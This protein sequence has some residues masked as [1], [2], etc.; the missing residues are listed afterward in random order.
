MNRIQKHWEKAHTQAIQK[1]KHASTKIAII[2]FAFDSS[3]FVIKFMPLFPYGRI[4]LFWLSWSA[5]SFHMFAR[6]YVI[7]ILSDFDFIFCYVEIFSCFFCFVRVC[8]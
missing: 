3:I 6:S 1:I 5:R 7:V 2:V 8:Q 4:T